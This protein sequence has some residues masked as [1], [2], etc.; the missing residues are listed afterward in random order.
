MARRTGRAS[1]LGAFAI[2]ALAGCR[3]GDEGD[4]DEAV[5]K[6]SHVEAAVERMVAADN[7]GDLTT[8]IDCY[9]PD[10]LLLAPDGSSFTGRTAIRAHMVDVFSRLTLHLKA[11]PAETFVGDQGWAWQ[12]GEFTGQI[13]HKD[14]APAETAHDRYLMILELDEGDDL[15]RI[16]RLIWSPAAGGAGR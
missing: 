5:Y 2:A 4:D 9:T 13:V 15:W 10:A 3:A 12:R 1:F 11:L 8:L 16:A 7:A 6:P 14:G